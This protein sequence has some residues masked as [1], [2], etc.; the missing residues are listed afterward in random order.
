MSVLKEAEETLAAGYIPWRKT[1]L[2]NRLYVLNDHA[3]KIFLYI[4]ENFS[5]DY[6]KLPPEL[7]QTV[8]EMANSLDQKNKNE[9][10]PKKI[11]QPEEMDEKVVQLF[12][13][14]MMRMPS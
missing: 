8:R 2:F 1:D 3:N 9:S 13:K 10:V 11:L 7:G 6:S 4:L 5:E 12:T 14:I